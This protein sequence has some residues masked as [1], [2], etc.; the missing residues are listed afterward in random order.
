[1][2]VKPF[3]MEKGSVMIVKPFGMQDS[4][5]HESLFDP[6][7][8]VRICY[9]GIDGFGMAMG[10]SQMIARGKFFGGVFCNP[11]VRVVEWLVADVAFGEKTRQM[12]V[13][14]FKKVYGDEPVI[15]D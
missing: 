12:F 5:K 1:M 7:K 3:R 14:C 4:A 11:K 15:E 10:F 8:P 9:Y 13:E 2:F 6:R